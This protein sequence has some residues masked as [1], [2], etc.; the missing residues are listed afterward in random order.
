MSTR[1]TNGT[2]GKVKTTL[3]AAATLPRIVEAIQGNSLET[4]LSESLANT[5]G[6]L[7]VVQALQR[8]SSGNPRDA[9]TAALDAVRQAFG[10]AYA[11]YWE[12][13]PDRVLR[14]SCESGSVNEEFRQC[15][16][17]STFQEGQGLSGRAW[18]QRD[19][20]FVPNIGE[21]HDC[22]RAPIALRAGVRAGMAIPVVL[23]GQVLGVMDFF[24]LES[25]NL[26]PERS[27][28]VRGVASLVSSSIQTIHQQARQSELIRDGA[29]IYSMMENAP[30]AIMACD[31][32]LNITYMNPATRSTLKKIEQHLPVRV[33]Q[34]M[35]MSIDIFHR[36]PEHQRKILRDPRNLPHHAKITVADET[37]DLTINAMLDD[38]GQY[39]GPML[40]WELITSKVRAEEAERQRLERERKDAEE[41]AA[42]VDSILSTV[43]ANAAGDLTREIEVLGDDPIGQV[44]RGLSKL[45]HD[46]RDSLRD[47]RH[48]VLTVSSAAEQ[49]TATSK[50]MQTNSGESS[51]QA[52][53]ASSA[54]E[55]VN[56]NI[57]M[58]ASASEEMTASIREIAKSAHQAARVSTSAVEVANATNQ[59][60]S[61]LGD[62]SLEIGKVIK[63][64]SSIAQQ[65]NLLAL[66]A[67]IEAARAGEAGRGF[68]VVANEVKELAKETAKA[69]EDITHKIEAIQSDSTGAVQAIASITQI[70]HEISD[71]A[72]TI[73]GAV[74]QQSATTSEISRSVSEAAKG[75]GE[76]SHAIAQ[77]ATAA[78]NSR[79][80][81]DET[82]QA[83]QSLSQLAGQLQAMISRFTL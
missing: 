51:S 52:I 59:T 39:I 1:K 60:I 14:F 10:W 30:V 82:L 77:V 25:V 41:L 7:D 16:L 74:E 38:K 29:R 73:A 4:E 24:S 64:I 50:Q 71:I 12:V 48:N 26:S 36:H 80:G 23:E 28:A 31:L 45:V 44:G 57:Q 62:S 68:A 65:T 66:N 35:G 72:N 17:T 37:M 13:Q 19:L 55:Q 58:V 76:I 3:P 63:V 69:T 27:Q 15:T 75:S 40:T 20:V 2:N 83:A 53:S 70:I 21:V 47:I 78:E 11:S 18:R 32:D 34:M 49:L 5:R 56:Q 9:I 6:V 81:A 8:V 79:M 61:K 33:E 67:T 43:T 54:G 42:K 22:P 46:L